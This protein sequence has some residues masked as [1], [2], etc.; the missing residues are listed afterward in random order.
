MVQT[1]EKIC[2]NN[3]A[4]WQDVIGKLET[5]IDDC[6]GEQLGYVMELLL[7]AGAKDVYYTPVYM[8]KTDGVAIACDL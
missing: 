6:S 7:Q 5:N 2:E 4:Y 8:K 1:S 3:S